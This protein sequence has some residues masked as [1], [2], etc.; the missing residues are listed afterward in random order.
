MR[1]CYPYIGCGVRV[2]DWNAAL[3]VDDALDPDHSRV[4]KELQKLQRLA[5]LRERRGS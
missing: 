4:R 1:V 5:E 2:A 3:W